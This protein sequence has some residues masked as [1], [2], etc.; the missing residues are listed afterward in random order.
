MEFGMHF[1]W[2]EVLGKDL[3]QNIPLIKSYFVYQTFFFKRENTFT[4]SCPLF[5]VIYIYIYRRINQC[6]FS[7]LTKK[8]TRKSLTHER[9]YSVC[10]ELYFNHR[11]QKC[12]QTL[13]MRPW[14]IPCLCL[15]HVQHSFFYN[16]K[17]HLKTFGITKGD[18]TYWLT[19]LINE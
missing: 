7:N 19:K 8:N 16:W 1:A 3:P 9:K 17:H 13:S 12:T 11:R 15:K 18:F 4:D 14:Q 5:F 10:S 2:T 6:F